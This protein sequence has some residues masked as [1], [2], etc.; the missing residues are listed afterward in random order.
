MKYLNFL[1]SIEFL[2]KNKVPNIL[3]YTIIKSE[4]DL[5]KFNDFPYVLKLSSSILHKTEKKGVYINLC[6]FDQLIKAYNNLLK[7]ISSEKIKGTIILQKQINGLELIIGLK[8]D[9][10]FSKILLFGSGGIFTE[11]FSDA[12]I[13]VLPIN[14]KDVSTMIFESKIGKIL[15]GARKI[16]YPISDLIKLILKINDLAKKK[17]IKELDLNP[18]IINEK[19]L[20]IVDARVIL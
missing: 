15:S 3:D 18:V 16:K 7:L 10:V 11:I 17:D 1:E 20:Y 4:K 9:D 2:E 6:T 14:E 8:D 19:G 12:S 13:R 5:T